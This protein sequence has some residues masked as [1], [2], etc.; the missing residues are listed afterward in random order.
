M[1]AWRN[2]G[3]GIELFLKFLPQSATEESVRK[4]YKKGAPSLMKVRLS[5]NKETGQCKGIGWLTVKDEEDAK[6][7]IDEWNE[8][9]KSFMDG[10]HVNISRSVELDSLAKSGAWQ[11]DGVRSKQAGG[12]GFECRFGLACKRV[13]CTFSHPAGWDPNT[14]ASDSGASGR[15]SR[16][17]KFGAICGRADCLFQ[18]PENWNPKKVTSSGR[19][20]KCT[21]GWDCTFRGCFYSHPEG[22]AIDEVVDEWDDGDEEDEPE[23]ATTKQYKLRRQNER[24]LAKQAKEIEA[25]VPLPALSTDDG[26]DAGAETGSTASKK[27]KMKKQSASQADAVE[28]DAETAAPPAKKQKKAKRAESVPAADEQPPDE[29]DEVSAKKEKRMRNKEASVGIDPEEIRERTIANRE[30]RKKKREQAKKLARAN[31]VQE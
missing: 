5:I 19:L 3:G 9:S 31:A 13:D 7:L 2:G 30:A 17:C 27:K 11:G 18:H 1:S 21:R 4:H 28:D 8:E 25:T 6:R 26:K 29:T 15:F 20:R 12:R 16:P 10:R 24:E 22:R 23:D 14:N